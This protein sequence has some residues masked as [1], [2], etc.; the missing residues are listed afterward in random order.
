M[1]LEMDGRFRWGEG[2]LYRVE[3]PT[4]P[5]VPINL[6]SSPQAPYFP[7]VPT[8][9]TIPACPIVLNM[10]HGW[11]EYGGVREGR[12]LYNFTMVINLV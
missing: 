12:E 6:T 8:P 4:V 5:T 11:Y 7:Q 10:F 3:L 9:P 1:G 2:A